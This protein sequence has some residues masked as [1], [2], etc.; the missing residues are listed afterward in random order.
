MKIDLSA[1]DTTE[2]MVHQHLLNGEVL[3][4]VQPQHI[5]AKW[6]QDN[7]IFR[8]SLWNNDGELVS[9]GFPKFPNLGESP[10]I[11]PVPTNLKNATIVNKLDGS[12]LVVSK[13]KGQYILRT[14]GTSDATKFDNG[15]ELETFKQRYLKLLDDSCGNVDTWNTS[16]LFEWLTGMSDKAIVLKYE[17]V[18][19]WILIGAVNHNNYSLFTQDTLDAFAQSLRLKRPEKFKFN[20]VDE[21]INQ[22]TAWKNAEGVVLYTKE[23]QSLH[24]IK[25]DDYKKKHAFKSNATLD[26]TLELFFQLGKPDFNT[27]KEKISELYDWECVQMCIGH[28]SNICDAWK[29]VQQIVGGMTEFVDCLKFLSLRKQ[30]AEKTIASYGP[31][32]RSA[33]VFTLLDGKKLSDD[34]LKKLLYQCLKK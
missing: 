3:H 34:Q 22:V 25:S 20:T 19:D 27:F 13:N 21:L 9:A 14:R 1:I 11:F 8:S 4:L 31:T 10:D 30:Q 5:G 2:F 12:L 26:N 16:F 32:N 24:K 18:P 28:M 17:H 29:G 6:T 33:M 15:F 23:D 7:K